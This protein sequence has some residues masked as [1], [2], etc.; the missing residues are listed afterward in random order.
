MAIRIVRLGSPRAPGEGTPLGT[1]RRPPPG[2][3]KTRYAAEDYF[4]V[5]LPNLAPSAQLMQLTKRSGG[6]EDEARWRR[7]AARYRAEMRKPD[8]R[9]VLESLAALSTHANF[10]VGCYC[11]DARRC[12]RSILREML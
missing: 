12:H 1:V 5:W 10:S 9:R 8:A 4:D 2:G 7:F 6:I 3:R 11:E